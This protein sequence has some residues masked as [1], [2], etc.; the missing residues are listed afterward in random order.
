MSH[1]VDTAAV[2]AAITETLGRPQAFIPLHEPQFVGNEWNYVKDCLDTGWVSSVGK[3]VDRFEADVAEFCGVKHAVAVVN[4][5]AALHVSLLLCDVQPGDEVLAPALTF[6]A[7]ANAIQYCHA[8]P[9]LVDVE[10]TTLGLSPSALDAYLAEIV[11]VK[12]GSC[13]NR[14]TGRRIAAVIPMHT[15]GCPVDMD[16][17]LAVAEKY[18]F[19]VVED[20]AESLGSYYKGTHT[21][22]FGRVAA[23]SFN[24]N[25]IMTTGGGGMVLTNDSALAKRA[26]HMTTTAKVPHRWEFAHDMV[27]FNYRMPNINA[28][29]GCAQLERV[30]QSVTEKRALFA[31]YQVAFAKIDGVSL[32]AEPENCKSNYWLN[33]LLLDAPDL[34]VRDA[35]L[36]ATN[37]AGLMTRP[38]WSLMH[39]MAPYQ[40]CPRMD[41]SVSENLLQRLINIPSSPQL[42]DGSHA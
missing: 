14:Q 6:I 41:L 42:L 18:C 11:E 17:M 40:D 31:V 7:T 1:S 21:G 39:H 4:G 20:A 9:H 15:F 26:K 2:V 22:N 5:T 33:A 25:K 32:F 37:D 29:L 8:V 35:I 24:G 3:Y 12:D 27:G 28:A 19:A 23:M 36:A 16:A 10:E 34:T 13:W 30:S 38:A